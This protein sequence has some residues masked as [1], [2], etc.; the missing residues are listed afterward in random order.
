MITSKETDASAASKR[1]LSELTKRILTAAVAIPLLI[2]V[3]LAGQLVFMGVIG[4]AVFVGLFECARL[5]RKIGAPPWLSMFPGLI[6]LGVPFVCL[7]RLYDFSAGPLW[8]LTIF[9][10]T[11][12]AD[13]SAYAIGRLLGRTPLAPSISP[14]KTA[15]GLVGS[16]AISALVLGALNFLPELKVTERIFFG[17]GLAAAA[18]AG[19]LFESWLKRR[20][21]VKDSGAVFPGHGGFLD[22]VDSLLFAAP[23]GYLLLS[24]WVGG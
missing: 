1:G 20:A 9:A 19:D 18:A 14:N 22:R 11:W 17:L 23:T 21:G 7:A 10:A 5:V 8:V 2:A 12:V 6:Y 13:T 4:A 16:L 3:I 15:E 24:A